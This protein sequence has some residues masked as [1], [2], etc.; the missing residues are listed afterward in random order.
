LAK[1]GE[2][3]KKVFVAQDMTWQHREDARKQ[4]GE[5]KAEAEAKNEKEKEEKTWGRWIVVGPRGKKWLQ[6]ILESE[7]DKKKRLEEE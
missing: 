2:E 5:M 4:E 3:W 6:R 1:K 7:E